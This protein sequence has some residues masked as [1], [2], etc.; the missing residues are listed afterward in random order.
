MVVFGP[1]AHFIIVIIIM[2]VIIIIIIITIII[3]MEFQK[4]KLDK[5]TRVQCVILLSIYIMLMLHDYNN[6]I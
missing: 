5:M 3:V 6:N 4:R 2:I 1:G